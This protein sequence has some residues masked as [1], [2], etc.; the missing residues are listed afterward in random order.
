[1]PEAA[2][3]AGQCSQLETSQAV[4]CTD[5]IA[6]TLL[7]TSSGKYRLRGYRHSVHLVSALP[8]GLTAP[9]S[10]RLLRAKGVAY[11]IC[12]VTHTG[13]VRQ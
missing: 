4:V 5:F 1:M 10:G 11:G 8:A 9:W 2:T 13:N 12:S 7:P 6:E 3:A